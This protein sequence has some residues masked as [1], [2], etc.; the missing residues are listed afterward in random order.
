M[1]AIRVGI[2][3]WNYPP[4]RGSFYPPGL[5][6]AQ[7]LAY[8]SR[9]VTS[10]EVNAT[11]YGPQKP[12]SFR[13][14]RE[15]S[16]DGFVFSLKGPRFATHRRDLADSGESVRRFLDTGVLELGEKLGPILWQFPPT[17]RFTAAAM[18][19]FL[20]SLPPAHGGARLRHAVEVTHPS[21]ADPD[22]M[23]LLR[24]AGIAHAIMDSDKHTL[25]ADLTAPFT[26]A[27]L[28]RNTLDEPEGYDS[29]AL[30]A[31]AA[32]LRAWAA[33]DQISDLPQVGPPSSGGGAERQCFVYFIG[34]DKVRAPA[35]AKALIRRLEAP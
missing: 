14:W 35:A 12:A 22:W 11:F 28:Q 5:P 3:G 4:W 15:Q 29:S 17:R 34:G 16:P 13:K 32:R 25:L 27:R 2:G 24:E 23:G 18:R 1:A 19:P 6:Q 9:N 7:E 26:Y 20:D 10:I 21:F 30:D 31:W 8:A 33:G